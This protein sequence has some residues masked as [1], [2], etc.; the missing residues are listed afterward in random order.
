[1]PPTE[2]LTSGDVYLRAMEPDDIDLLYSVENDPNIFE[3][4]IS[5]VPYSRYLLREFIL[6]STGDIYSDKQV[7]MMF[8]HDDTTLGIVDLIDFN[9][10]QLRAEV[11][12]TTLRSYRRHGY[13]TQAL[14][15]LAEYA[16]R[17]LHLHHLYAYIDLDNEASLRLFR[18]AGYQQTATLKGWLYDGENHHDAAFMQLFL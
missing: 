11:G 9:P 15:L 12:I 16:A 5:N 13:G 18:K 14:R 3:S 1:M 4:G 10:H 17:T 8:C 2:Y 6:N 7:R